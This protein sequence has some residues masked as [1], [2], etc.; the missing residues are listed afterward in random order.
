MFVR[1]C[2]SATIRTRLDVEGVRERLAALAAHPTP[3]GVFARGES[4]G[5][6]LDPHEFRFDYEVTEPKKGNS[7]AVR[8]T[9][10][11]MRDWR[12]IRLKLT[13]H[14]PWMA[15][16]E[17]AMMVFLPALYVLLGGAPTRI[18]VFVMLYV[19]GLFAYFN[20]VHIP[21]AVTGRIAERIAS[22]IKGSVQQARGGW[23]VPASD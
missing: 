8:G 3:D 15:P 1:A 2:R 11:D 20:L 7:Y 14:A 19:V 18:A 22:E 21:D 16:L 23:V 5:W 17:L 4:R 12:I 13:A 10:Q 9:V 6:I